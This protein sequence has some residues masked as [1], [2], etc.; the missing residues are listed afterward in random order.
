MNEAV[1]S[2]LIE[3]V[4]SAATASALTRAAFHAI[5]D[6][7]ALSRAQFSSRSLPLAS[8]ARLSASLDSRVPRWLP[9]RWCQYTAAAAPAHSMT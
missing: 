4:R 2:A 3:D 1:D 6:G 5:L 9:I 7:R 8:M